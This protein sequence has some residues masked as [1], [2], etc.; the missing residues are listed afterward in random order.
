LAPQC[1]A[2]S[3]EGPRAH[4]RSPDETALPL[5]HAVSSHLE[6]GLS[7]HRVL[8]NIVPQKEE[9]ADGVALEQA[10]LWIRPH[11]QLDCAHFMLLQLRV[12]GRVAIPHAEEELIEVLIVSRYNA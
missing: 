6:S 10:A 2:S 3:D 5:E 1:E 8:V 9:A 11:V 12:D 4:S 7:H